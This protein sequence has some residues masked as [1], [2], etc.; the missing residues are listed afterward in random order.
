MEKS[1]APALSFLDAVEFPQFWCI[2]SYMQIQ[3]SV[4]GDLEIVS[5]PTLLDD[6][7]GRLQNPVLL[8][9]RRELKQSSARNTIGWLTNCNRCK[10]SFLE[11][12]ENAWALLSRI[13]SWWDVANF[14]CTAYRTVLRETLFSYEGND[15]LLCEYSNA[16][17]F[18]FVILTLTVSFE[19]KRKLYLWIRW[20]F[21]GIRIW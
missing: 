7:P 11:C 6:V 18:P 13:V 19:A 10:S 8:C 3:S 15:I 9:G 1:I 21:C 14:P 16:W 20:K 12:Y 5:A 4:C 2:E 17:S